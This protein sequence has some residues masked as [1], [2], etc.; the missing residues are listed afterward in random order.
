MRKH[1][2]WTKTYQNWQF[3]TYDMWTT[4][5]NNQRNLSNFMHNG[6]KKLSKNTYIKITTIIKRYVRFLPL[7][8]R[9]HLN[10]RPHSHTM[11]TLFIRALGTSGVW[12]HGVMMFHKI[13]PFLVDFLVHNGNIFPK[14]SKKIPNSEIFLWDT[15][16][17]LSVPIIIFVQ[18][19]GQVSYLSV[20][21]T[22]ILDLKVNL[23]WEWFILIEN[24]KSRF[25]PYTE[26]CQ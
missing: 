7:Q 3:F 9:S 22:Y 14:I 12:Y 11:F 1:R 8:N 20:T 19:W 23:M 13:I 15:D 21:A 26:S 24:F 17:P 5:R 18:L 25:M 10:T 6:E 4:V 16:D 2:N